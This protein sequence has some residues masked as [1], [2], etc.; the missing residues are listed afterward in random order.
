M[1]KKKEQSAIDAIYE[2]LDVLSNFEKRLDVI[3]SNVKLLNNKVSK[4]S[5]VKL[6]KAGAHGPSAGVPTGKS[7]VKSE[8]D[9]KVVKSLVIGKIKAFGY[10]V[11]KAKQPI[12]D[13][14]VNI[15]NEKSETIRSMKTDAEG[16]WDARLPAGKYGVE[17][18]CKKFKP[19]NRTIN[20]QD[21]LTEY[22]VQ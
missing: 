15:Y 4:L 8:I 16:Y 3:D 1:T 21:N 13:V 10:I 18:L 2:I 14:V 11:N 7:P 12:S 9:T 5:K 17:Y 20:L 22:R 19:I 6:S